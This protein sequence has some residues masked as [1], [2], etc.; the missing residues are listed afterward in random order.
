MDQ[1]LWNTPHRQSSVFLWYVDRGPHAVHMATWSWFEPLVPPVDQ[2]WSVSTD[3]S[4]PK[5]QAKIFPWDPLRWRDQGL[6]RSSSACNASIIP[7][8]YGPSGRTECLGKNIHVMYMWCKWSPMQ[9]RSHSKGFLKLERLK[10]S[11]LNRCFWAPGGKNGLD[12]RELVKFSIQ[13]HLQ[14]I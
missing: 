10:T 4:L 3:S 9:T 1:L 5:A 6:K 8:N 13:K 11:A 2:V 12:L 7:L 14:S